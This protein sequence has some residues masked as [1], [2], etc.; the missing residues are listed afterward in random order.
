M[1]IDI[2]EL[3][4]VVDE[5]CKLYAMQ[6]AKHALFHQKQCHRAGQMSISEMVTIMISF[7]GFTVTADLCS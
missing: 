7:H 3:Y 1:R 2:I 5:F 4:D 6:Q